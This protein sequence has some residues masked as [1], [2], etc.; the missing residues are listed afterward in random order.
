MEIEF[1][2]RRKINFGALGLG[3]LFKLDSDSEVIYVKI[4]IIGGNN[5]Y[6][7]MSLTNVNIFKKVDGKESVVNVKGKLVIYD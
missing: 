3:D 5:Y 7:A 1:E 4:P 6:N 2:R